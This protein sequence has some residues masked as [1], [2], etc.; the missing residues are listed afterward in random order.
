MVMVEK[1]APNPNQP[2][3]KNKL[4]ATTFL[5][6]GSITG[7][8]IYILISPAAKLAHSAIIV[9]FAIDLVVA[10]LIAGSYAE[11][12]S[13]IPKSGGSFVFIREA[14]GNKALFIGWIV[15]LSNIAYGALCAYGVAELIA[16][17]VGSDSPA[18]LLSISIGG[19]LLFA[20]LNIRG[21]SGLASAQN[22]LIIALLASYVIGG[23]YLFLNPTGAP[24]FP[25]QSAA[26]FLIFRAS[27]LFFDVFIGF[28]DVCAIA[29]EV[30]TPKKTIPRALF[31]CLV[32]A[33]VFFAIVLISLTFTQDMNMVENSKIPFIVAVEPNKWVYY[34]VCLGAIL[35][36][37]TSIGVALMAASRNLYG[38]AQFDFIDRRWSVVSSKH[39]APVRALLLSTAIMI[40]I[41]LSG[42]VTL[43]ASISNISYIFSV[44]FVAL[45]AIKLR[46]R[47]TGE[48]GSFKMPLSP[49]THYLAIGGCV[50]LIAFIGLDS[51]FV[52][53]TWFL[54]GLVIYLF[55]SS[56]KR[57]YGTVFLIFAFVITILYLEVG[58]FLLLFGLVFYLFTIA[59]K[60]SKNLVLAG[61][62][63][64]TTLFLMFIVYY[65]LPLTSLTIGGNT[66]V[67]SG[68][69]LHSVLNLILAIS[70]ISGFFD[71]IPIH[72]ILNAL[73]KKR[74][75]SDIPIQFG[76]GVVVILG[77]WK[78][79]IVYAFNYALGILQILAAGVFT[80]LTILFFTEVIIV[81]DVITTQVL[82]PALF[83][84]YI[85][86]TILILA[87]L[88]L[89]FSG[90]LSIRYCGDLKRLWGI[91][92]IEV[93]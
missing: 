41:L 81:G 83:F 26:F 85:L 27:S 20:F 51:I 52:T 39:Q 1:P 79:R 37:L 3:K 17:L 93:D 77:K 2:V 53:V 19:I 72:E 47:K 57:V 28:E 54:T 82:I 43:I 21:S 4:F 9:A 50:L 7:A 18:F 44:I 86:K 10:V 11:C 70:L 46:K 13:R 74:N 16:E 58:I 35:A 80:V 76:A 56:K 68:T 73:E 33:A 69:I 60:I 5:A 24:T 59:D 65:L 88:C 61:L 55:F 42:Q 45:S 62:K 75:R 48:P 84:D 36:L 38:L 6:I 66:E 15:W 34:F 92:E 87:A 49:L 14:F 67:F 32:V 23:V 8:G 63:I 25:P 89:L 29:E 31:L 78:S 71:V 91:E 30:E 22:P 12:V 64:I 90:I 40:L